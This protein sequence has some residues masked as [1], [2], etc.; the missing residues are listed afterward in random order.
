MKFGTLDNFSV[1]P[2]AGIDMQLNANSRNVHSYG[3]GKKQFSID[4]AANDFEE[5]K[6]VYF[7]NFVKP[8]K[9][10]NKSLPVSNIV[11]NKYR[12]E[13]QNTLEIFSNY[14]YSAIRRLSVGRNRTISNLIF[15]NNCISFRVRGASYRQSGRF[16][17]I[18][19][20]DAVKSNDFDDKFL[21]IYFIVSVKH[22]FEQ[23]T[24]YNDLMCVKTY[25]FQDIGN[26]PNV[27]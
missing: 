4:V 14:Y 19:R 10:I 23:N 21:G 1:L 13:R 15:L 18:D 20:N 2:S 12:S 25:L 6:N 9:G 7:N 26:N 5:T 22:I 17:A 27:I 16:I 24:Y 8:M 3:Y 11:S